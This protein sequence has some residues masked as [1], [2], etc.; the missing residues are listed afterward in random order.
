ML[1]RS[2][3]LFSICSL[4]LFACT[5]DSDSSGGSIAQNVLHKNSGNAAYHY[6]DQTGL[7]SDP[8]GFVYLNEEFFLNYHVGNQ[9]VNTISSDNIS[10]KKNSTK[11]SFPANSS[12]FVDAADGLPTIEQIYV[13]DNGQVFTTMSDE[14]ILES[15]FLKVVTGTKLFY[16]SNFKKWILIFS[17]PDQVL[18]YNSSDFK[19]WQHVGNFG[20]K[21][22][23]H[24]TKPWRSPDLFQLNV[25]GNPL[26]KKWVLMISTDDGHPSKLGGTQYF[27]G[28][29]DGKLFVN[30]NLFS[31]VLWLDWGADN[32]GGLTTLNTATNEQTFIGMMNANKYSATNSVS[33][34]KA[35]LTTP[36]KL[37][38]KDTYYGIKL[39][40][41]PT[42]TFE[43]RRG[44]KISQ[45]SIKL[46]DKENA[47][48]TSFATP[49]EF[50]FEFTQK[51]NEGYKVEFSNEKGASVD[52]S[53]NGIRKMYLLNRSNASQNLFPQLTKQVEHFAPRFSTLP[54]I[55]VRILVDRNSIE[56]F[57]DDGLS[58]FS[59]V[60]FPTKP[61]NQ[62]KL[63]GTTGQIMM[64]KMEIYQLN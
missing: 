1:L 36:R 16:E 55:N 64:D 22:G 58:V 23:Y 12:S 8:K 7:M 19:N 9:S 34:Q 43:K 37:E 15:D 4:T 6:A 27:V 57:A 50:V 14:P 5:L 54:N 44:T 51:S 26:R 56:I 29:F 2:L 13:N 18:F 38:L 32:I 41:T 46:T 61:L 53:Y 39:F 48:M 10:W 11:T 60:I 21:N 40:A 45:R 52:F 59:E 28:D 49:S 25:D 3:L 62:M 30:N 42:K 24:G 63:W 17:L 35:F 31:K 20:L 47:V 33:K